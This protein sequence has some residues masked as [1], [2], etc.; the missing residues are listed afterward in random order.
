MQTGAPLTA[1]LAKGALETPLNGL[2][3]PTACFVPIP[4]SSE[5]NLPCMR[6]LH[7]GPP[8][9]VDML[10]HMH[11]RAQSHASMRASVGGLSELEAIAATVSGKENVAGDAAV[12]Q[13]KARELELLVP[14]IMARQAARADAVH[15][16]QSMLLAEPLRL[17]LIYMARRAGHAGTF[18]NPRSL[19]L[20]QSRACRCWQHNHD[21]A[22]ALPVLQ[23]RLCSGIVSAN[24][25]IYVM[26]Y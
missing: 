17:S 8:I 24:L 16:P 22:N 19:L 14:R 26:H 18:P 21:H 13:A 9:K 5:A 1:Q 10:V 6:F 3:C 2:W 23:A 7:R 15:D 11:E 12:I 4:S 20:Q 25:H